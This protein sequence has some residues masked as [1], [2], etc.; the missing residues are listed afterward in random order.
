M[1]MFDEMERM[2]RETNKMFREFFGSR[3]R[4]LTSGAGEI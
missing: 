3:D 1:D 4:M 2:Y